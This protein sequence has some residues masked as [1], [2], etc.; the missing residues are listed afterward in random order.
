MP[1]LIT[2]VQDLNTRHLVIGDGAIPILML[3]GWGANIDLLL[4]LAEALA[5][6]GRYR[7]YLLDLP[8][9]G[10]TEPPHTAWSVHEYAAFV[11]AY[12]DSQNLPKVHLFGHSFGGRLSFIL[13]AEHP[14]RFNRI[15]L[16]DTAGIRP[17][18]PLHVWLRTRLYKT[19]RNGLYSLGMKTLADDL[20]QRYNQQYGSA[21]FQNVTGVMRETFVKVVNEDLQPYARQVPHPTLLL[22]GDQ[23]QDTPLSQARKL[24]RI[25]PDAGLVIF[26]GA[27]HYSYL[28]SLPDVVRVIDYFFRQAPEAGTIA[29]NF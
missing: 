4:P 6:L 11:L 2:T 12:L 19:A 29:N 14:E 3:H 22:W 9:F 28:E 8:G 23:D 25:M 1:P 17:R 13:G 18:T 15:V 5:R 20:R 21:D 7:L 27:G 10:E 24:E 26:E 16:A